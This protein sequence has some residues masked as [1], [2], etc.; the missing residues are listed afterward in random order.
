MYVLTGKT[1]LFCAKLKNAYLHRVSSIANFF[2]S[3]LPHEVLVMS[4]GDNMRAS[5]KYTP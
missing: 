1:V 5:S 3:N 4:S 2:H